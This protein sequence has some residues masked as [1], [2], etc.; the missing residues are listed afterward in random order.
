MIRIMQENNDKAQ[1][2]QVLEH[3][4]KD[5]YKCR[6]GDFG[7]NGHNKMLDYTYYSGCWAFEAAALV[8][9]FDL[10]DRLLLKSMYYPKDLV[11]WARTGH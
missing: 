2:V 9:L 1:A 6:K 4:I 8:Y 11:E 7:Y 5:R 3:Y 10:D